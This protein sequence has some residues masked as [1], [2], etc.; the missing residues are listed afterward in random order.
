MTLIEKINVSSDSRNNPKNESYTRICV[1][2]KLN[3]LHEG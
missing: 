2:Y 1:D 3:N